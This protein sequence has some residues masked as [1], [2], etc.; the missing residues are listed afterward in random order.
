MQ[1]SLHRSLPS[2]ACEQLV[3]NIEGRCVPLMR[4]GL[5]FA[6]GLVEFQRLD[7]DTHI[8]MIYLTGKEIEA[9]YVDSHLV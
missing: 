3:I 7:V 1:R 8:E 9:G 6:C 4:T 2:R 5:A